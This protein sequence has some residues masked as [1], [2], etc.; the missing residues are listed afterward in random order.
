MRNIIIRNK[1]VRLLVVTLLTGLAGYLI[2]TTYIANKPVV[3]QVDLQN[4]HSYLEGKKVYLGDQET[5]AFL[6]STL[7]K[8][9]K[10]KL[11]ISPSKNFVPFE[12][13]MLYATGNPSNP[14]WLL[15]YKNPFRSKTFMSNFYVDRGTMN[16]TVDTS[17]AVKKKEMIALKFTN[18]NVQTEACYKMMNFK[19]GPKKSVETVA[20]NTTIIEKYPA[21]IHLLRQLD[22]QKS[23]FEDPDLKHLLSLFDASVHRSTLFGN[24]NKY[25]S[26]KNETGEIFPTDIALK[27]PDN[28]KTSSVLDPDKYNLVVFWAS[29]CGPCRQEIPQI[30]KLYADHQ[31]KLSVTSISIDRKEDQWRSAVAKEKMPWSQLLMTRDSSFVKLDKKYN[32]NAIPVWV[33]L[34]SQGKLIDKQVGLHQ[35]KDAIDYKVASYM[36]QQ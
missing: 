6:D 19:A 34:D 7:V 21:S 4:T 15:G 8:N 24:L 3:I 22:W 33:L 18:M 30:K 16:F 2:A 31:D 17:S 11:S 12:A 35:G 14:Y 32:L 13:A 23:N 5:K 20:Y 27:K 25:I 29:W 1:K 26:Y 9:G 10:F 28:S 36:E